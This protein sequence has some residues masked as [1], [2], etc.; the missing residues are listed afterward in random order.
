MVD[1]RWQNA[2]ADAN[3]SELVFSK[4]QNDLKIQQ[5]HEYSLHTTGKY[6]LNKFIP[7]LDEF[8]TETDMKTAYGSKARRFHPDKNIGLENLK[9]MKM[10][11]KTKH[12]LENTLP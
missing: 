12:G 2:K 7:S 1:T 11:N 3:P 4:K 6:S 10:I 5:V 8:S 9:M